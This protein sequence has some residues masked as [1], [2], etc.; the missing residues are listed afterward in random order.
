MP[1][2]NLI[3]DFGKVLVDY[4][5]D[6]LFRRI[7]PDEATRRGFCASIDKP[8]YVQMMDRGLK[9]FPEVIEDLIVLHPDLESELRT[10]CA[11]K[12]EVVLGEMPGMRDLLQRYKAQGY[13]LYGLTNWDTQVYVTIGQFGIFELL[14]DRII[15]SEEHFIK[16]EPEIYLRLCEKF[17]VR[18]EEC[19][20]ADD[21]VEN[22]EGARAIGMHGIVFKDA[23]QYESE[24]KELIRTSL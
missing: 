16:P 21:R 11:R 18:P 9:T 24:L 22:I 12:P 14:D 2:K 5:F 7:F 17:G 19:V 6:L 3:F 23:E 8:E 1:I 20:F 15:S 13:K 4:D 10:F